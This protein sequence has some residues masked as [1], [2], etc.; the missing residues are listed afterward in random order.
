MNANAVGIDIA[1]NVFQI[2]WVD[3][4]T[5][6]LVNRQVKRQS[7][8]Q[9]FVNRDRCLIGME[10]CGGSQHWAR[11]LSE[12]GH[13]VRLMPGK[14]VKG[15]VKGNKNDVAD[16]KAIWIA[17]QQPGK[18]VA[19]KSEAQQA[20]LAL[21]RMR[22]QLV[23]FRTAQSNGLRGLLAEYGVAIAVGRAALNRGATSAFEQLADRLPSVLLDTLREQW[24][25]LAEL[26]GE[27]AT[28][29]NRLQSWMRQESACKAI[30]EI[31]GVGLL[32]ATAAVATMADPKA[33]KSGREFA[34]FLG[35]VPAQTGTGGRVRL[36]GI[37]KR[38]DTY[39]RTLLI[40]GARS[41]LAHQREPGE[42]VGEMK[43]RRP[44][45]V[46]A[47]ALANKMAR[48]IWAVLAHGQKYD[49]AHESQ[50]PGTTAGA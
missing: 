13:E 44:Q 15:F 3:P 37:S 47:V 41:V 12:L 19:V 17:V 35:L 33:F 5:G 49:R 39:L 26:D 8:L 25:R 29:E 6:E 1:K 18:S 34:A 36:L 11:K 30:A 42:W 40:H 46:V 7:L 45:N 14:L 22:Q 38:G 43:K 4:A 21:H 16:A 20:V 2:C 32:T 23:K 50:R 24:A 27:I 28:I 31:P 10:A 9:Q 48:T